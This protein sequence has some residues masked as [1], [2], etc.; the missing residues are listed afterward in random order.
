M[1][2]FCNLCVLFK[3]NLPIC[4]P[5][6]NECFKH[7]VSQDNICHD[8]PPPCQGFYMYAF[9][10]RQNADSTITLENGAYRTLLDDYSKYKDNQFQLFDEYT[11]EWKTPEEI[12]GK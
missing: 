3:G 6:G 9:V 4:G 8:L 2:K 11:H 5:E 10:S 7:L 1:Q 12:K